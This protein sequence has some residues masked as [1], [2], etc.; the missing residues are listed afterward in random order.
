MYVA[1]AIVLA[2]ALR[3]I[4]GEAAHAKVGGEGEKEEKEVGVHGWRKEAV[5]VVAKLW[6]GP[7]FV[8]PVERHSGLARACTPF[9]TEGGHMRGDALGSCL[10]L[11][12]LVRV[13]HPSLDL[14][15]HRRGPYLLQL[16]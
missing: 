3:D 11:G 2:E 13:L 16:Q 10:L 6:V 14:L 8:A 4:G 12:N 15:L 5:A 9:C 7:E 1:L